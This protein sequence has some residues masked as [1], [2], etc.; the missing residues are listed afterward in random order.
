MSYKI[1]C[2]TN[3]KHNDKRGIGTFHISTAPPHLNKNR[4]TRKEIFYLKVVK[5]ILLDKKIFNEIFPVKGCSRN[6]WLVVE[7]K[8]ISI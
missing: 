8:L 2:S 1:C 4:V 5:E 6:S 7:E 3:N